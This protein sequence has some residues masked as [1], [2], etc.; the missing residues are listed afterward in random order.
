[1]IERIASGGMGEVY[2]AYDAVLAREVAIKV[3]HRHLAGDPG[4]IDRFRTE[5]RSAAYLNHPNIV[6]VY[7]WGASDGVYFMVMEYVRGHNV[8]EVLA[9]AGRMEPAQ[10][11]V[12]LLQVLSALEHAHRQGIVHR[13]VKPENIL[14]TTEGV[15]KV[16]D[17]GLARAYSDMKST[18]SGMV[19]GTVQY[20]APEQIRGQPAEPRTDVYAVGVVGYELLTG[21]APFSGETSMSIAYQHLSDRIQAPS[22]LAPT[23]PETLDRIVLHATEKAPEDRPQAAQEMRQEL[24]AAAMELPPARPVAELV[25]ELP[26][27]EEGGPE[28][29]PTIR[30]PEADG[31][32]P[33][34]HRKSRPRLR[35]ALVWLLAVAALVAGVW[36]AWT[37]LVPHTT[38]VPQVERLSV[39]QARQRLD[40]AGLDAVVGKPVFSS[41][42]DGKVA[43]SDPAAGT[44]LRKG[45]EVTLHDSKGPRNVEVPKLE[46]IPFQRARSELSDANLALGAVKHRY[47]DTIDKGIVTHQSETAK[48]TI[49]SGT[50]INLIVS[51]GPAPVDIP[52]LEGHSVTSATST[53]QGLGLKVQR[54]DRFDD[55]VP[56]GQVMH[57]VPKPGSSDVHRG[58]SVTLYVSKGPSSFPIPDVKGMSAGAAIANLEAHGLHV[59]RHVVPFS[60]GALVISQRPGAGATVHAG[61]TVDIYVG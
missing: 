18:Q 7:D 17:F 11:A 27:V 8:R 14:L 44:S 3:L 9:E 47:S 36:A 21:H 5:A 53:L 34:R 60:S 54:V 31:S 19:T 42:P 49:P 59:V 1:V 43:S 16:A 61:D 37:F 35:K 26:D 48:G 20:L 52:H 29:A 2:R 39:N 50:K 33:R 24:V 22:E 28:R 13:D 40:K 25:R 58:D 41:S 12:V 15:A 55:H 4:F 57:I 32:Q 46:G 30:I 6:A 23:V 51:K 38:H 10:A 56:F 45:S